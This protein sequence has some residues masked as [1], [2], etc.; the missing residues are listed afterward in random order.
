MTSSL[1]IQ[2]RQARREQAQSPE[3]HRAGSERGSDKQ[4]TTRLDKLRPRG[5][6]ADAFQLQVHH[7]AG[8]GGAHGG[9]GLRLGELLWPD[10]A[11]KILQRN[12]FVNFVGSEAELECGS[13]FASRCC[14]WGV[15]RVGD[16]EISVAGSCSGL[17]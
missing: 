6:V 1:Q 13:L 2:T 15:Y 5:E 9:K 3:Q 12:I 17:L 11:H 14:R 10:D 16:F 7:S 8:Q 4:S